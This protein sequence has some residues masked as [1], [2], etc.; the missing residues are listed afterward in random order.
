MTKSPWIQNWFSNFLPLDQ[1]F[2]Y[3]D[4]I[5]YTTVENFF[6]AMKTK[7][8]EL[9]K[10]IAAATPSQAKKLGRKLQ[11]RENWQDISLQVMEYALRIKFAPGTSW[12]DKLM[13]TGDEEIVEWSNWGDRRWGKTLDGV[14]EN[15]LGKLLMKIRDEY[16]SIQ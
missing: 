12:Y 11:L 7:D 15:Q 9:R 2:T 13:A 6:Q 14:G 8:L 3:K 10:Q 1:P 5:T 4:G 16:K